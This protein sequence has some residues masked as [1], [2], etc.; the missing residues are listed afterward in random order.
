MDREVAR[1]KPLPGLPLP[2]GIRQRRAHQVDLKPFLAADQRSRVDIAGVGALHGWQQI[3][4][5]QGGL[6][7]GHA[8]AVDLQRGRRLDVGDEQG[9]LRLTRFG[10]VH[11]VAQP[12][13]A[14]LFAVAGLRVVRRDQPLGHRGQIRFG[15][16]AHLFPLPDPL[17]LVLLQPKLAQGLHRGH[18]PQPGRPWRFAVPGPDRRQ[19]VIAVA[20]DG[21]RQLIALEGALRQPLLLEAAFIPFHPLGPAV[22]PEPLGRHH[23]QRVEGVAHGFAHR[24]QAAQEAHRRQHVG[25]VGALLAPR[26]QQ[27]PGAELVEQALEQQQL[28]R[29]GDQTG[30]ELAEHARIKAGI[31][32]R[33]AQQILPVNAAAH[34]VGGLQVGEVLGILEERDHGEAP[35]GFR[36][37]PPRG[38]ERG[39]LFIPKEGVEF[40]AQ[41]QIGM[42]FGKGGPGDLGRL[43]RHGEQGFRMQTH[44][45]PPERG[46]RGERERGHF[47]NRPRSSS[48]PPG[49]RGRR[50]SPAALW[51]RRSLPKQTAEFASGIGDARAP[52][53]R[54]TCLYCLR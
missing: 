50:M 33:Q 35:G 34:R 47:V 40:V 39:K 18:L 37:L 54:L 51:P 20:A 29:S 14:P 42:A 23:R 38:K 11:L 30:A 17:A 46:T 1:G 19:Q 41:L 24:L 28:R 32:Q 5:L 9:G 43:R 48:G 52:S 15:P 53:N 7:G 21:P 22:G 16:P 49:A 25:G 8:L 10:E 27:P 36:R 4:F 45:H 26:L 2:G 3:A 6:N 44:G 12:G 13:G 31:G